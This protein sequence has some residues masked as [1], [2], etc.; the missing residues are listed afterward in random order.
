MSG[1]SPTGTVNFKDGSS[2]ISGCTASALGGSGNVRTATC[3][4]AGL[5]MGTHSITA[6]YSGDGTN[7]AATSSALTQTVNKANASTGLASSVNPANV[8]AS[9]TFTAT[10]TGFGP[11]GAINFKDGSSSITGCSAV[12]LAG[13]GNTRTAQC[14]TNGLSAATHSIVASYGGDG[15]NAASSSST[16]SEVVNSGAPPSSLVNGGFEIPA[17]GSASYQYNPSA[18]GIGWTFSANSGIESN[19]SAWAAATAPDG[20]QAAFIQRTGSISQTLTLGAGL[21]TLSFKAAQ[22]ACCSAPNIQPLRITLDGVQVGG[23]ISPASTSFSTYRVALS[24]ASSGVHTIG[25]TGT[26]PS[27]KSTFV[28]SVSLASGGVTATTATVASAVDP[29]KV[30]KSVAFTAT[31]TGSNPTGTVAF[32][33]GGSK[34]FGCGAVNL[35][36]SGNA[37][38]ARCTTSFSKAGTYAIVANYAGD[39][40]NGAA[41]STPLS[42]VIQP[43]N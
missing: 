4:T 15:N 16:L 12:T 43:K 39:G 19:G 42:Q 22:R 41:A 1:S 6:A 31:V 10:V 33:S 21:Y 23:L 9:I 8:G 35:A 29:A 24:V 27:D 28:D 11:T 30:N 20:T 34:I 36:G 18:A 2:S 40:G 37:K 25:F 38:T 32:T 5:T 3:A 14:S 13:S 26:D 17:L 7:A